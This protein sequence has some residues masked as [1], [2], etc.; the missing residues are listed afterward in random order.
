MPM[1]CVLLVAALFVF[2][3]VSCTQAS[4]E[5]QPKISLVLAEEGASDYRVI[6]SAEADEELIE[7]AQEFVDYFTSITGVTLPIER[8]SS[9]EGAH[10]I[11][12]GKTNRTADRF[13]YESNKSD[14][15]CYQSIDRSI[16]LTGVGT[17]GVAYAV[18]AFLEEVCGVRYW[19]PDYESVP[20]QSTLCVEGPFDVT[21]S[22]LFSMRDLNSAGSS[23]PKWMVKMRLNGRQSLGSERF[24]KTPFVGGGV[25]YAGWWVHTIASLAEM[26]E[27]ENGFWDIQPCLMDE[28][29]YQTVL[30]NVRKW[31]QENPDASLV[32]ISQNDGD[33][34]SMC[35]CEKC[36]AFVAEHGGAESALW[37]DFV[38]RIA[39]EL[40]DEYPHVR[41]DTLSYTFTR[42][43]PTGLTVPNNVVVR[44]APLRSC[45]RHGLMSCTQKD[46]QAEELK[47]SLAA[48]GEL[49]TD[50]FHVWE[51]DAF[52]NEYWSPNVN[53]SRLRENLK[54]YADLGVSGM[55]IQGDSGANNG[56]SELRA[57]L[58]AKLLWDPTMD[59]ETFSSLV[60]DFCEGYYGTGTAVPLMRYM[61]L[62]DEKTKDTHYTIYAHT[63]DEYLPVDVTESASGTKM[64]DMS[65]LLELRACFDEAEKQVKDEEQLLHLKKARLQIQYYE[66]LCY[67]YMEEAFDSKYYIAA[68]ND[69]G[70]RLYSNAK[71]VGIRELREGL[72]LSQTTTETWRHP[73]MWNKEFWW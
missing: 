45:Y 22:P 56:F 62:V 63:A 58:N 37:I 71:E 67:H 32:S 60:K 27:G 28:G 5:K 17:R 52:F 55:F 61:E 57:Y 41:F 29:V 19:T 35:Q 10:E 23:D 42:K 47:E 68:R 18:Y 16:L 30:K 36:R 25:G 70:D 48:W 8:D 24:H 6:L 43:A 66:L 34:N 44:I 14:T 4:P 64:L 1:I 7:I 9:P 40:G 53:Y 69:L 72:P 20:E 65:F 2:P 73:L 33:K 21:S 13:D 11:L 15:F 54:L 46:P 59:D 12:I 39:E 51:Y 50:N 49:L 31:L 3:L 38:S 26:E